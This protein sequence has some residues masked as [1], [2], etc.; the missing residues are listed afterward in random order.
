M[1]GIVPSSPEQLARAVDRLSQGEL[2]AFPTETVYGLGCDTFNADAI[3]KVYQCKGRP[4]DNPLIAHLLDWTWVDRVATGWD[5]LCAALADAFW[6]GALTLVLHRGDGVPN[7]ATGGRDTIAVRCPQ[8]PVARDLLAAFDGPVSA[9]SANRSGHVSPTTAAHVASE[10]G[11][12]RDLLIIDGGACV[13]G[14]ESTVVSMVG[15]ATLLRP[16]TIGCEAIEAIIGPVVSAPVLAQDHAPGT[17]ASHYAPETTLV[18]TMD[19]GKAV[20]EMGGPCAALLLSADIGGDCDVIRMP[21]TAAAYGQGLYAAIRRADAS[22]A[23]LI[24]VEKP[25]THPE[26]DAIHDRLRRAAAT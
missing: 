10:F 9:P 14:I 25:P 8:H 23:M 6:P 17:A 11:D 12:E 4:I 22:D 5:A 24:V 18:V 1:S 13:Q 20:A 2:V 16:G 26:W 15:E 7:D 3:Q 19:P 21:D